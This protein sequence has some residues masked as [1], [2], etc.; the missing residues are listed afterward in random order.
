MILDARQPDRLVAARNGSPVVIGLGEREMFI[1]SDVAALVRYTE[2][3]VYLD[4]HEMAVI[5]SDNFTTTTIA[6]EAIDKEI[7][8]ISWELAEVEKQGHAHFMLKEIFEQ[9]QSIRNALRGR[10]VPAEGTAHLGGLVTGYLYLKRIRFNLFSEIQYRY[11]K[12]R[13]NRTRRKFDVYSGG[14]RDDINRRVH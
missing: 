4:D 11:L 2:Q 9:S 12:W 13:I 14:R 10:L 8:E 5:T 3:V 6:N 7:E 1:A